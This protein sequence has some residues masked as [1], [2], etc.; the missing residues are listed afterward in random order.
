MNFNISICQYFSYDRVS[1]T[2]H[3]RLVWLKGNTGHGERLHFRFPCVTFLLS[4]PSYLCLNS[5][6]CAITSYTQLMTWLA[7]WAVLSKSEFLTR[8]KTPEST[9][10]Y[11]EWALVYLHYIIM[12]ELGET[13]YFVIPIIIWNFSHNVRLSVTVN[14]D[15]NVWTINQNTLLKSH[16][17]KYWFE[18][19]KYV[20]ARRYISGISYA[21]KASLS[22]LLANFLIYLSNLPHFSDYNSVNNTEDINRQFS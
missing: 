19:E 5:E 10:V 17:H 21:N 1:R 12:S 2:G 3:D 13:L 6:A 11:I 22:T 9:H 16:N 7:D 15:L 8:F 4:V 18:G 20:I 14:I